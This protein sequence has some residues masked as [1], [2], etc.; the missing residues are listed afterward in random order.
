MKTIDPVSVHAAIDAVDLSAVPVVCTDR[1]IRRKEQAALARKLFKQL[2]ITG[3]SVTAPNYS[4]AHSVEVK[5]PK[6]DDYMMLS[7]DGGIDFLNDP[8]ALANR[9]ISEKVEAILGRA[10]PCHD[11]RSDSQSDYFDYKWS[12]Q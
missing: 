7:L 11:D 3:L 1:G 5:I 2:G 9:R 12:I 10:F 4:M 6:R 8:T